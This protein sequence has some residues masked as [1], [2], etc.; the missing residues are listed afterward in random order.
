MKIKERQ[1]PS[2]ELDLTFHFTFFFFSFFKL[3]LMSVNYCQ[4]AGTTMFFYLAP[5]LI[6]IYLNH[7]F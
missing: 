1:T 4:L 6:K 7:V 3:N 5:A 2:L